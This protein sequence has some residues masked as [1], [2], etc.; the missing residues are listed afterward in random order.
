MMDGRA[1]SYGCTLNDQKGQTTTLSIK[2]I[3]NSQ[4]IVVNKLHP[5]AVV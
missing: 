1:S 3:S 2:P 4:Y 5:D